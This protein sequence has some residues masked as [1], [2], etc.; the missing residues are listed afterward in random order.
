MN[1]MKLYGMHSK[2]NSRVAD[3]GATR[4]G[5]TERVNFLFCVLVTQV[6]GWTPTTMVRDTNLY[7]T[8][9]RAII[10]VLLLKTHTKCIQNSVG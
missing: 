9:F 1:L 8:V 7:P 4:V 6:V 5:R 2:I 3:P 10:T